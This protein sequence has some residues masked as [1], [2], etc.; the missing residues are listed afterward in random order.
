[1]F[2]CSYQL[3]I[4]WQVQVQRWCRGKADQQKFRGP[5]FKPRQGHV[6]NCNN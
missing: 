6:T 5:R 3:S 4:S 1:M 2:E